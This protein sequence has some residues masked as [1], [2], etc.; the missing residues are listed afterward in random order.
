MYMEGIRGGRSGR[1]SN[2]RDT[3]IEHIGA[4]RL[5][6]ADIEFY[7]DRENWSYGPNLN[8]VLSYPAI[9]DAISLTERLPELLNIVESWPIPWFSGPNA[10]KPPN[11]HPRGCF[12]QAPGCEATFGV[13]YCVADARQSRRSDGKYSLLPR[14]TFFIKPRQLK[15]VCGTNDIC[16]QTVPTVSALSFYSNLLAI[17][18]RA[19]RLQPFRYAH[20]LDE[21]AWGFIGSADHDPCIA[22]YRNFAVAAKWKIQGYYPD[23]SKAWAYALLGVADD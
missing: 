6:D 3:M 12:V 1:I 2:A 21:T 14:I 5:S 19:Y 16:G 15:R 20:I 23:E 18:R 11:E 9:S 13:N 10:L 7:T 8:V 17:T 4:R 22:V